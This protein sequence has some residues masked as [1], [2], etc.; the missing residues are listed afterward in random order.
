MPSN[1]GKTIKRA[2][3]KTATKPQVQSVS[4]RA[5]TIE[6]LQSDAKHAAGLLEAALETGDTSDFMA[7]LR[8]VAEA[9]GGVTRIAEETGLN[10]E[11][12]YRTL[13]KKGNPQLSSLLPILQA[14]GLR[15]A[16]RAV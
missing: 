5:S 16:V 11:A 2:A 8:L 15:L 10:R 4:H 9:Q 12:L 7:A 14:A 1:S 13:S 6:W 3:N